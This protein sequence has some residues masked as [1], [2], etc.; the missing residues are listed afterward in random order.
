[1]AVFVDQRS[2]LENRLK[3]A[4][5][6]TPIRWQNIPFDPPINGSN[7]PLPYIAF[8]L[9]NGVSED[10]ALGSANPWQRYSGVVVVQ[11]FTPE[12]TGMGLATQ[13]GEL[14]KDIY[15]SAPR[16]IMLPDNA[17]IR[18]F[19][20]YM[21]EIGTIAGW[22]QVNVITPFKMDAQP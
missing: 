1:M 6:A 17:I 8:N 15:L 22:N 3:I 4:W 10:I 14:I 19:P 5:T 9:R 12:N 2:A 7:R 20:P 21:N 16:Q 11:I 18:L 13:Y